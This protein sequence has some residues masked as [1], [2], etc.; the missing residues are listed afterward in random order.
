MYAIRL[1]GMGKLRDEAGH[2]IFSSCT[3]EGFS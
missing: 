2:F 3:K 1:F